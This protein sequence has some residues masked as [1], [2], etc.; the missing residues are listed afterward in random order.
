MG[1]SSTIEYLAAAAAAVLH[2]TGLLPHINAGVMSADDMRKL[3]SVSVSQGLMLESISSALL[4]PGNAHFESPDKDPSVR[5]AVLGAA[6]LERIPFTTGILVGIGESR[7]DRIHALVAIRESHARHGHIQ[8]VIIQNFRAKVGTR[9]AHAAEPSMEEF[10][11]TIA[12]ARLILGPG[13]SIQA[14]PNLTPESDD[15]ATAKSSASDAW[16]MLLDAGIN[17]WG[18]V[19]PLTRDFVNPERPWP[20]IETLAAATAQRGKNLLP[21][22]PVYPS[23]LV[24]D[25]LRIASNWVDGSNGVSSPLAIAL[26]HADSLGLARASS[27]FAGAAPVDGTDDIQPTKNPLVEA[28]VAALPATHLPRPS[29]KSW[30]VGLG[31]DG[32]L[33]GVAAQ[34]PLS[35]RIKSL[36]NDVLSEEGRL[37]NEDEIE[38]LFL[39]RGSDYDSILQAAD[40][41]RYRLHGDTVTYVVNRNINYTNV[42]TFGCRFC[43]FSK[44]PASESLRGNPYLL[45]YDEISRRTAEAWHR[46]ATEVC[47]QGGIHPDFTGDTYLRL[48]AAAK[49][50]APDVHI[51]AFSPL[52]VRHGAETLSW[53]IEK[54]LEALR[55]AGLGSLPG[56]AAEVL[57]D[58]IREELCPDKLTTAEWLDVLEAA[59]GLGLGTTSTIMFGHVD[60]PRSWARHLLALRQLQERTGGVSEFVPLPFVHMEAP[61]YRR[62]RARAGPTLR[63]CVL[64]HAIGRL[65][66]YP[67][68]PNI[69]ASWVKMGPECA[70]QLL[71]A[72]CNDMGGTLM[73][74]SITRAAGAQHG[75]ELGPSEM[76]TLIAAEGRQPKQRTTLYGEVSLERRRAS[77]MAHPLQTLG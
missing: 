18:G 14:P 65:V 53:S 7:R 59:H 66:L 57:D 62:G 75:Q 12:A 31:S 22:L 60:G 26:K 50:G 51:H 38:L 5:L 74:E 68:V 6:G 27:W 44:G 48:L 71:R 20:H 63:E 24:V 67:L 13:M 1:Y 42:C 72:G 61:N 45:S 49:E 69:Q 15:V 29:D 19:S 35:S 23:H 46:G 34:A 47:M 9:M 33:Q 70:S 4:Q 77:L 64:M 11:W 41:L 32:L 40:A 55:D 56:T 3:K 73:N 52:E 17:D 39:Q 76:E 37:L 2:Q 16:G 21:R 36:L 54:Y 8:E 28:K 58:D 25:N 30:R 43:A 10:L